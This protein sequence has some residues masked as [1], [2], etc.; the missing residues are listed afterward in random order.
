MAVATAAFVGVRATDAESATGF[1]A[2]AVD[3][4]IFIQGTASVGAKTS[5]TTQRFVDSS[6]L[7]GPFNFTTTNAGEKIYGWVN[8]LTPVQPDSG[9]SI[10]AGNG[11][12]EGEWDVGPDNL[13]GGGW[14]NYV[15]NPDSDFTRINAGSWVTTNNPT[16]LTSVSAIGGKI[17]TTTSIMGN[18]NNAL[19]D[20]YAVGTGYRIYNGDGVSADATF[21]TL[22]DYEQQTAN[23]WGAMRSSGGV[24]YLL[25][26]LQIGF[27]GQVTEFTDSNFTVVWNDVQLGTGFYKLQGVQG[28]GTTL[29]LSNGILKA[30]NPNQNSKVTFGLSGLTSA[31]LTGVNISGG[32]DILGDANTTFT[33]CDMASETYT[34]GAASLD[35]CTLR[36]NQAANTAAILDSANTFTNWTGNTKIIQTGT[37]HAFEI[38][39]PGSVTFTDFTFSGFGG[40]PGSNLTPGS[41]A[42][43][44]AI[45]NSS[46]GA[47]TINVIGGTNV[48][49]RN[50]A[51]STTTVVLNPV[52][53]RVTVR[54]ANTQVAIQNAR[55]LA[56][57]SDGTG[58]L[59]YQESVSITRS[60][61]TATVTHT[62]HGLTTGDIAWIEGADQGEYNGAYSVTVT[63]ANTYTYTVSGTPTSPATGTITSTGGIFNGL[64]DV[65]GQIEDN[66]TWSSNQP[67]QIRARKGSVSPLYRGATLTDTVTTGAGLLTTLLL[68]PDE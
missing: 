1:S 16:Q 66:R 59:P 40:T 30:E 39:S 19:V 42:V 36:P 57:A 58:D 26:E 34:L 12:S 10:V 54:D 65:N 18:F 35:A 20:S 52:T 53:T 21:Q 67:L 23:R 28:A 63:D 64:T 25:G 2:G 5:N 8:G 41:G 49:V 47:V 29:I 38:S 60:G 56:V 45:L 55:V 37:G 6:L 11:T 43:D 50:T 9:F 7:A 48:S 62:S 4:D 17:H 46:G 61:A 24:L 51:G 22:I 13:Y 33:N 15:A 44:A 3:T 68:I 14:I 31:T 32:E 27:G